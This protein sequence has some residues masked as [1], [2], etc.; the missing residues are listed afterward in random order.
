[1]PAGSW[2]QTLGP[3][4][5]MGT[6]RPS[7]CARTQPRAVW[8][9]GLT[10]AE[11]STT[12]WARSPI[13]ALICVG[14]GRDSG[15]RGLVLRGS[16]GPLW[17]SAGHLPGAFT[18]APLFFPTGSSSPPSFTG[19]LVKPPL[20]APWSCLH[21]RAPAPLASCGGLHCG[22]FLPIP[23]PSTAIPSSSF[24]QSQ[25]ELLLEG[26]NPTVMDRP[27]PKDKGALEQRGSEIKGMPDLCPKPA[28]RSLGCGEQ[29]LPLHEGLAPGGQNQK[30][31]H[32]ST[33]PWGLDSDAGGQIMEQFSTPRWPPAQGFTWSR[34]AR[35]C[36]SHGGC[37]LG[38]A[39][40]GS[41]AEDRC[42]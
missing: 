34:Q 27:E 32:P 40:P 24:L 12:L 8:W 17:A 10:H 26:R 25:S 15:H 38:W 39:A 31:F 6:A 36:P 20:P 28:H 21:E 42:Q 18:P 3:E 33:G 7:P 30:A 9:L 23:F 14:T 5:V 11:C 13:C 2:P 16:Q 35:N 4:G 29:P 19:N 22:L 1:M 37:W 41:W